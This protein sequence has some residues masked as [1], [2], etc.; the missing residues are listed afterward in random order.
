MK[1]LT[2]G[3]VA[4]Q[5]GRSSEEVRRYEKRGLIKALRTRRGYRL[6]LAQDVAALKRRLGRASNKVG[7]D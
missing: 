4:H 6:F 1:I 3:E 7:R 5:L 2:T